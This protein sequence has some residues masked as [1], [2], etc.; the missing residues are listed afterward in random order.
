MAKP[1]SSPKIGKIIADAI[2]F[3]LSEVQVDTAVQAM[4]VPMKSPNTPN[5]TDVKKYLNTK[6][7]FISN[8]Y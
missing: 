6:S 3:V 2:Q 7:P 1:P 8:D 4:A 5:A